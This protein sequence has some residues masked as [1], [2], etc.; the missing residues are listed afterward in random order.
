MTEVSTKCCVW[1][2]RGRR[3]LCGLWKCSKCSTLYCSGGHIIMGGL[4]ITVEYHL[5]HSNTPH[6]MRAWTTCF[7]M[8][9]RFWLFLAALYNIKYLTRYEVKREGNQLTTQAQEGGRGRQSE[10]TKRPPPSQPSPTP[11]SSQWSSHSLGS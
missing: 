9:A 10:A 7:P 6:L 3:E 2:G 11:P 8:T 1:Q 5:P 4:L